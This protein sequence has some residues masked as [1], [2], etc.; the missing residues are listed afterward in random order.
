MKSARVCL[1]LVKIEIF[2]ISIVVK[3]KSNFSL[4]D[5]VVAPRDSDCSSSSGGRRKLLMISEI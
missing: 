3:L 1:Q 2:E 5:I 4:I